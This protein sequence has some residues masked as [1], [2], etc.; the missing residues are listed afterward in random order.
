M[1]YEDTKVAVSKSQ[2]GIRKLINSHNGTGLILLSEPPREGFEA[3][4]KL[5]TAYRIRIMAICR[6][7]GAQRTDNA[8]RNAQEQEVRR[9]WRVLYWHLKA[10]F[11]AAD[12]GVID[13]RD[14]ILP[15]IVLHDNQTLSDHVKP[16]M[17]ELMNLENTARLL[18]A[19]NTAQ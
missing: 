5:D 17:S 16:R 18:P 10:L 13:V 7:I 3:K 4:I 11:E 6:K 9:V 1:A 12:S 15:Y 14:V 19:G 8:L 2:D